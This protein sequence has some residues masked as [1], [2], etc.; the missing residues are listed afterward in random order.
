MDVLRGHCRGSFDGTPSERME[1]ARVPAQFYE[2][3][4]EITRVGTAEETVIWKPGQE[5][6]RK[7]NSQVNFVRVCHSDLVDVR[8]WIAISAPLQ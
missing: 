8:L 5:R 3:V 1:E 2:S 6:T 4:L 7:D